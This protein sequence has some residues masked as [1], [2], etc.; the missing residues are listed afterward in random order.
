MT[1]RRLSLAALAL[2]GLAALPAAATPIFSDDFERAS[3]DAV[4]HGWLETESDAADVAIVA[5]DALGRALQIRDDDPDAV[6]AQGGLSTLGWTGLSLSYDWAPTNNTELGDRLFVE[7]RDG[8]VAGGAWTLLATH[9]LAGPAAQQSASWSLVG[10][11]G[12]ADFEFR[13][14]VDV[15]ANNEGAYVDNVVLAG[16]AAHAVPEPGSLALAGLGL[17]LLP[18]AARRRRG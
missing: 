2:L 6:A 5:R 11:E 9:A 14:R 7:W 13:F 3:A 4:G 18:F 17:A 10:A 1:P 8:A 12:I 16:Q 15:D